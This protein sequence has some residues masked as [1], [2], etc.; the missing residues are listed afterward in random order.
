LKTSFTIFLFFSLLSTFKL[1]AQNVDSTASV[2]VKIVEAMPEPIGG[3]HAIYDWFYNNIDKNRLTG[4][5]SLDCHSRKNRVIVL[6]IID[7]TGQLIEPEIA[8]GIGSPYDEYCLELVS[9]MPI[10]WT[11]ATYRGRS[12]KIRSALPFNFCQQDEQPE[13]KKKKKRMWKKG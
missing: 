8:R 4:L 6:F 9:R 2:V 10:R 7:E 13:P 5:D 12:V 1:I 3:Y 11:P